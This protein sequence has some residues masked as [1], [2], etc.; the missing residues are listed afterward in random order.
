MINLSFITDIHKAFPNAS[1]SDPFM[2]ASYLFDKNKN[3]MGHFDY[4]HEEFYLN[5]DYEY[6]K[7]A[8]HVLNEHDIPYVEKEYSAGE[9]IYN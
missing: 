7:E 9:L 4:G 3:M 1:V 6:I 5:K 8:R 2:N